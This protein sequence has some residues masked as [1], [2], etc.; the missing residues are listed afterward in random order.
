MFEAM[1]RHINATTI[2]AVMALI[3]AMT[4]GAF[5]V[6]SHGGPNAASIAAKKKGKKGKAK[7]KVGPAGPR[8]PEGKQG[9]AGP[10][11]PQGPAGSQG[12]QGPQGPVGPQGPQGEKGAPGQK[13]A[14][15][16]PWTAGGTLPEG[17]TETGVWGVA[18]LPGSFFFGELALEPIS[19]TIPLKEGLSVGTVHI[20]APGEE[21]T[22]KG[23]GCPEKSNVKSP[24][25]EP[26][27]VCIFQTTALNVKSITAESL[28]TGQEGAAGT[29]GTMLH[30][31]PENAKESVAAY[32][33]WAVTG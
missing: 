12:P 14:N 30:I 29:T 24:Q 10:A 4:G 13:G 5:A 6:T 18:A 31:F 9:P 27:N 21:G 17:S 11:G 2:I 16:S 32:G 19:F 8:G 15:G 3:F 23:S 28:E 25:A 33:T 26:G 22:G 1:R 20:L 7:V